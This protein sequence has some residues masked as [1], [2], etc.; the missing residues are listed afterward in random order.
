[1]AQA[2]AQ[3]AIIAI[4]PSAV[5][6]YIQA[7]AVLI[8]IVLAYNDPTATIAKLGMSRGQYEA[9]LAQKNPLNH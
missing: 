6:P 8:G 1:L 5:Q 2:L 9:Q 7:L 3:G 4:I